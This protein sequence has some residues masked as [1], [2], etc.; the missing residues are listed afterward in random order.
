MKKLTLC[1]ILFTLFFNKIYGQ[2]TLENVYDTA[3]ATTFYY[4]KFQQHGEKYVKIDYPD[5]NYHPAPYSWE[6]RIYNLNHSLWK[7]ID[8]TNM[9]KPV[10]T[11]CCTNNSIM[12]LTDSLFDGDNLIEFMFAVSRSDTGVNNSTYITKWNTFIYNENLTLLFS[13]TVAGPFYQ[14]VSIPQ[15]QVPIV[16]T[17]AGTKMMLATLTGQVKVYGL[18]GSLP[19]Q[20]ESLISSN[21][22]ET[23]IYPNPSLGHA[24]IKYNLPQE[25]D[26][27]TLIIYD[28]SGRQLKTFLID[29]TF[30][31]ISLSTEDLSSGTYFYTIETESHKIIQGK[32]F[33]TINN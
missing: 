26:K 27:A 29:K 31:N 2:F 33:V 12:Y 1:S 8:L 7:I 28:L 5:G 15:V 32:K 14:H 17:S 3:S 25:I 24:T 16:N 6:I 21:E 13:D 23:N 4:N 9:P 30:D 10:G 11:N 20:Y 22:F 18:S 19:T